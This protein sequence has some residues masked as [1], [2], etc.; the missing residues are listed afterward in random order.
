MSCHIHVVIPDLFMPQALAGEAYAGLRL[1]ALE[2]LLARAQPSALVPD[3]LE[4]WLCSDFGIKGQAIAPVLLRADGVDPGA[5]YWLRA[6]PVCLHLRRDQMILQAGLDLGMEEAGQLCSSLNAHFDGTG[7][8][9]L[10]PH[11][12]RWYVRLDSAPDMQTTPLAAVTGR[13]VHPHLP[14]GKD[15]LHWHGVLNEVQML[16][17]GHQVNQ[18]REA[19]AKW[20]ANSIWLWGGGFA[21]GRLPGKYGR[22]I[23][24]GDLAPAFASVAGIVYQ[25]LDPV[26]LREIVP[27]EQVLIVVEGLNRAIQM[28][29]FQG[30]RERLQALE[31]NLAAPLLQALQAGKASGVTLDVMQPGAATRF[32]VTRPD[33]WKLWRFPASL[34][35]YA[36]A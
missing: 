20:P 21:P 31:L 23:G 1:P 10:A 35:K 4:D 9:F 6:D 27:D 25:S 17:Y 2:K 32:T 33:I 36:L 22:M 30:W 26:T 12:Q 3:K 18:A 24:D 5:G 14:G 7:M 15:A 19:A 29:D 34:G 28:E 16:L 11:P 8:H 13:D